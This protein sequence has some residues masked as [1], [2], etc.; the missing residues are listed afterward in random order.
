[1]PVPVTVV[2]DV[3]GQVRGQRG[4]TVQDLGFRVQGGVYRLYRLY[5][6]YSAY[7]V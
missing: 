2:G 1:M 3:H 7:R 5:G 4:R 6:L